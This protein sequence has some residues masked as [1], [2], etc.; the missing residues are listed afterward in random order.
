MSEQIVVRPLICVALI[1]T[2]IGI[3]IIAAVTNVS[4]FFQLFL[5]SVICVYLGCYLSAKIKKTKSHK[6]EKEG[7]EHIHA[8]V[9]RDEGEETMS[10]KDAYMFPV[11][12]S[13]VLFSIYCA[14]KFL[15]KEWLN[16]VFTCHFTF[17]GIFC[18]AGF[19]ELPI[20]KFV[21]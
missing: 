21:P 3:H 4:A 14:Y 12:G 17:I 8:R 19:M 13:M 6:N 11:Y 20:S 7:E 16:I 18:L 2:L 9:E 1:L 10:S 5:Q 15:P